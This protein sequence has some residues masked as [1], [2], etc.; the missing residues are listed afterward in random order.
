VKTLSYIKAS[1]VIF[2]LIFSEPAFAESIG[3]NARAIGLGGA[4]SALARDN[5]APAWNPANLGLSDGGNMTIR[6]FNAGLKLK[7][8][9]LSLAQYNEYTGRLLD[10]SDKENLIESIPENG[11]T[12][13][14]GA[15]ASAFDFSIGN[16][17]LTQK[18]V[19]YS[20][21]TMARDPIALL[22]LGNVVMR[23]V[24][25]SDTHGE[26][27]ALG[28]VALSYGRAIDNWQGGELSIGA[29]LHYLRGLAYAGVI[30]ADGGV[31]TTDTGFVG[32]GSLKLRTALGGNG[33]SS[34]I[35]LAL[36][37]ENNWYFSAVW[38]NLYSSIKWNSENE[39][40][41]FSFAMEPVTAEDYFLEGQDDSLVNTTDTSYA[42]D[43]FCSKV[44]PSINFGLARKCRNLTYS[45]EWQQTLF[46][47]SG[48]AVNPRIAAGLE[49]RLWRFLPLRTGVGFEGGQGGLYSIG[50]GLH[51][52]PYAFDLGF[53]SSGS[54]LPSSSKGFRMAIS[55]GLKF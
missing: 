5:E 24:E 53:A 28:D 13:D 23:K 27:Y 1:V 43:E 48:A 8:N 50:L 18:A 40:H 46:N 36:H 34:D 22:F 10:D 4:Y 7:N 21:M 37:F 17:A 20:S 11:L 26:S 41:L 35:G 15:E 55:M 14:L 33:W 32:A 49:Y 25:I 45:L 9:G 39:E 42:S 47:G 44:P 6:F 2:A 3:L 51:R 12:L 30:G 52:G 38:R 29:S 54:P 16:F 19:G 31:T